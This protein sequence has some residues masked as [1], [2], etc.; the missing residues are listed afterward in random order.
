MKRLL[1]TAATTLAMMTGAAHATLFTG[2]TDGCFGGGCAPVANILPGTVTDN[3]L[4]YHD[5]TFTATDSNGFLA[6]GNAPLPLNFNNLGSFALTGTSHVYN[7]DAFDLLVSFTN[8]T[9]GG[10][11]FTADL[12]G[13]VTSI[14]SGGVLIDFNNTPQNFA[15]GGGTFTLQVNDVSINPGLLPV[16]LTGQINVMSG[17][18]EPSTWAMMLLGFAGV[19]FMAY[20]RKNGTAMRLA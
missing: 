14:L 1:I 9:L 16:S 2:Y 5:S 11:V 10:S 3:G 8:P 7:G 17:V 20:R 18:P 19:G 4:S 6:L 15:F 12:V 13:S